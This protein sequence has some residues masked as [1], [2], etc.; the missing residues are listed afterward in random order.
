[1]Q[2]G[3]GLARLN[4]HNIT[5]RPQENPMNVR[6]NAMTIPNLT[7]NEVIRLAG[8]SNYQKSN[9]TD[10]DS[11][12]SIVDIDEEELTIEAVFS[13]QSSNQG[14]YNVKIVA[15]SVT[16]EI[17]MTN[18]SC[19][20]GGC[21]KHC[22]KVLV[23]S[24]KRIIAPNPVY[25][26]RDAKR[27]RTE[28]LKQQDICVYVVLTCKSESDSGSDYNYSA[29]VKDNFDQEILGIYFTL[30]KANKLAKEHVA[31]L[32][33]NDDDEEEEDDDDEDVNLFSWSGEEDCE[34]DSYSKVWVEK[35]PIED[36]SIA[37]HK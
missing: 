18:C 6:S 15:N 22:C 33:C 13:A 16:G 23:E 7:I 27:R 10:M 34:E 28:N 1:M 9:D 31:E 3:L 11:I 36:A 37:F 26:E 17:L 14:K 25:I 4:N 8:A 30:T 29:H 19:P 21:C 5:I 12:H 2:Y 32:N 24:T 20:V 35:R